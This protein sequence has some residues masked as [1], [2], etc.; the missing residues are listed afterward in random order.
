MPPYIES[1]SRQRGVILDRGRPRGLT[2]NRIASR[3]II[4]ATVAR[5]L[6]MSRSWASREAVAAGTR[7]YADLFARCAASA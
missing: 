4:A 1:Q 5:Q 2:S 3:Y 7:K 6:A